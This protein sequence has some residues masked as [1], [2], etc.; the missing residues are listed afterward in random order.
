MIHFLTEGG[1]SELKG[2]RWVIPDGVRS[3]LE[4]VMSGNKK[5]ELTSNHTTKEAYDHLEYILGL[6]NG[7]PYNE[8]KRIKN[9]FDKNTNATKTKQYELYGG[10]TMKNWVNNALDTATKIVKSNK[11]A[12]QRAGVKTRDKDER[13]R[14]TTAVKVDDK[15]P[16]YN[17]ATLNKLN[18]L[19]ELS[20]VKEHII[21]LTEKQSRE[22]TEKL[23]IIN[24]NK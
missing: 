21:V 8:M 12:D 19:K 3:H 1:N 2:R 9:W 14:Q 10:D 24:N 23:F 20:S 7:I 4:S 6:D 22:L 18:R 5:E 13:D 11:E 15:T 17:P 16:T